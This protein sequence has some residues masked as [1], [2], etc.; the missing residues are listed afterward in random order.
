[1]DGRKKQSKDYISELQKTKAAFKHTRA[2]P[3]NFVK[4][5]G[6]LKN[7]LYVRTIFFSE[8]HGTT[9]ILILTQRLFQIRKPHHNT[10]WHTQGTMAIT[11]LRTA[12]E[13]NVFKIL[14]TSSFLTYLHTPTLQAQLLAEKSTERTFVSVSLQR[15][16]VVTEFQEDEDI[17]TLQILRNIIAI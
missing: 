4:Q 3:Y 10:I 1:M 7:C 2:N 16:Q 17:I 11:R 6:I 14:F 9:Q 15:C 13:R 5:L 8:M 12:R